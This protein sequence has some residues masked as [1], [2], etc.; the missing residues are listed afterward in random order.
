MKKIFAS[1]LFLSVFLVGSLSAPQK[2]AAVYAITR[3]SASTGS[4]A[5]TATWNHT[6][7][8]FPNR[9]LL[10][11][12][13]G[14]GHA[15]PTV[16]FNNTALQRAPNTGG[17]CNSNTCDYYLFYE[18]NPPVGTY[19]VKITGSG[20]ING[21]SLTFYNVDQTTPFFPQ[22]IT[23]TTCTSIC[24]NPITA[25]T[26]QLVLHFVSIV[27]KSTTTT[28]IPPAGE[29]PLFTNYYNGSQGY[30]AEAGSSIQGNGGNTGGNPWTT[31]P[32]NNFNDFLT[33]WA[34]GLNLAPAPTTYTISGN[35][36]NDTNKNGI[37]D[38][39]E[40]N[41][42][43]TPTITASQGTVVTKADGSYTISGLTAGTVTVSL[44]S[45]PTGFRMTSP[46][47]GPPP[48]FQV[49]VGPGCSTNGAIGASCQ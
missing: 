3:D 38:N 7:G 29:M 36:F 32:A 13:N 44:T 43:G 18:L 6:V 46:L 11:S 28:I 30:Q 1:L 12:L 21:G 23:R 34:F 45:L 8:N 47:N 39:G 22:T 27:L 17:I 16:T 4:G 15:A 33:L 24:S 35:I 9:V 10:V 42:A 31:S 19:Q 20:P 25:S 37:K 26:D 40:S 2:A 41:Y 48:S 5:N 49:T 14:G